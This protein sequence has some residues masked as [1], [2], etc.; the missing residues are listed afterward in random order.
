M[1][2]VG[3]LCRE[4]CVAASFRRKFRFRIAQK[5]NKF[6]KAARVTVAVGGGI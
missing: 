6:S 3:F 2:R 1:A 5:W 4:S